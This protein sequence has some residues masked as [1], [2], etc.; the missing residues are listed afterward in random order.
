MVNDIDFALEDGLFKDGFE[1][2]VMK[3]NGHAG[4]EDFIE[5]ARRLNISDKR[6]DKLM[7]PFLIRQE[8]VEVLLNRSFLNDPAK[9]AY[10]LHYQTKRNLLNSV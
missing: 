9:R 7:E 3:K 10:L 4:L 5:F 2:E 6:R 1:S 8:N